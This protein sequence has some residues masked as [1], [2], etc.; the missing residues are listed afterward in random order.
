MRFRKVKFLRGGV[1]VSRHFQQELPLIH[2]ISGM[3]LIPHSTTGKAVLSYANE[4]LSNFNKKE[5]SMKKAL[6]L[7]MVLALFSGCS[8]TTVAKDFNGLDTPAG[9]AVHVSA[10]N[11]ALHLLM[12]KPLAGDATL[13]KTVADFTSQAQKEGASKVRIVQ[14]KCTKL[15]YLLPPITLVITPV[16]SNVAG[17][18]I[19]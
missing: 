19:D 1:E 8:T 3:G 5:I 14:S 12:S 17:D 2:R 10:S 6:A 18:A 11:I 15:W 7:L 4:K 9:K 13:Q 16:L